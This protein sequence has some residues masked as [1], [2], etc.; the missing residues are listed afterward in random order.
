M[1]KTT[2]K[3]KF[4]RN[5]VYGKKDEVKEITM[6]NEEI[7]VLKSYGFFQD[8]ELEPVKETKEIKGKK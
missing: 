3:V 1:E 7:E 8:L 5:C 2:K 4:M 6:L